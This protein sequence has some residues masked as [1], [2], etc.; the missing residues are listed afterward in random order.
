MHNRPRFAEEAMIPGACVADDKADSAYENP[1][2]LDPGGWKTHSHLAAML[3]GSS[4]V[5]ALSGGERVLRHYQS[6]MLYEL[7]GQR[8]CKVSVRVYGE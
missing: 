7:D 3:F 8:Q 6:V 4:E 2:Q 5:I 1:F